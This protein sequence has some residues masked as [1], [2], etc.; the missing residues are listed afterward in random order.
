MC[1][2]GGFFTFYST[3]TPTGSHFS[4]QSYCVREEYQEPHCRRSSIV[5][6]KRLRLRLHFK[7][8]S[9][10]CL[11][12]KIT[13]TPNAIRADTFIGLHLRMTLEIIE[14]HC[15]TLTE[16]AY[17]SSHSICASAEAY[18]QPPCQSCSI[19]AIKDK[20][21]TQYGIIGDHYNQ[22]A[23]RGSWFNSLT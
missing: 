16:H 15:M 8:F 2:Q 5:L 3:T 18:V 21:I 23:K 1:N 7:V 13:L 22:I 4:V 14:N 19:S 17:T 12:L 11:F 10:H 6:H 9:R 20:I